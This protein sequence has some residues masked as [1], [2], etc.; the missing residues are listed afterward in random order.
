ML[1]RAYLYA[2]LYAYMV[3]R[4]IWAP[5]YRLWSIAV[6]LGYIKQT[7]IFKLVEELSNEIDI[8]ILYFVASVYHHWH[9]QS[10]PGVLGQ[11][12]LYLGISTGLIFVALIWH[13]FF[14]DRTQKYINSRILA[15]WLVAL[16]Y[17]DAFVENN[18]IILKQH[19]WCWNLF[20]EFVT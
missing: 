20:F 16:I 2:I 19:S 13:H 12:N 15:K 7:K 4:D 5:V 17:L 9:Q 6:G 1:W 18:Y 14:A 3:T 10:W 11:F 8:N